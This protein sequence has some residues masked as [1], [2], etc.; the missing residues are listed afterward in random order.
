MRFRE[1]RKPF[2]IYPEDEWKANWDLFITLVLV[3]TCVATPANIAF[4]DE[5]TL[6]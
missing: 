6:A 3:Y 1:N 2:L 5:S 4:K